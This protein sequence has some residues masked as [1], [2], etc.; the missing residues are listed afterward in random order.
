MKQ[1]IEYI[2]N[3]KGFAILLVVMGHVIANWFTDFYKVLENDTSNDL[4]V[5]K[6]IYSFHMPLFMFCS[7]L[8]QPIMNENS[9]LTNIWNV[10]VRRFKV[11]IIPYFASGLLLWAVTERPSFYWFLLVLFE[12][13]IINL[14]LS[15]C[16]SKYT[17]KSNYIEG[18]LFLVI[19]FVI[20]VI[21]SRF[22][23][24]EILPLLDIGHLGLY[25]YFTI[26]YLVA[27]Y[28]LLKRLFT[29]GGYTLSLMVFVCLYIVFRV[30][31]VKLSVGG[32][33]VN[34]IM[35]LA[36]IYATFFFFQNIER[37]SCI[38]ILNWLGCHSL[39]IYILHFFFL[40]KQPFVGDFIHE[41]S[42]MG[43]ASRCL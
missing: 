38:N 40:V 35:P 2:D 21:T 15:F 37:S 27:K 10:V 42:I 25:L 13:T 4:M 30:L 26:G 18:I 39:E 28:K 31:E 29:N 23:E 6:L 33:I 34:P 14:V 32:I 16:A 8:F 43:G 20:H 22:K 12:F 1:R 11:L 36:A 24:N 41:A 17:K 3:V 19:F 9:T 7:G 5:W